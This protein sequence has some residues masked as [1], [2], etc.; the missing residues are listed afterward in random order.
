MRSTERL[1]GLLVLVGV[2]LPM[3]TATEPAPE[4]LE[5]NRRLLDIW[6]ADPDHFHRLQRDLA[7]FWELPAE[8]RERLR[9]LDR[10]LHDADSRTQKRLWGVLERYADWLERLPEADQQSIAT[11]ADKTERLQAIRD[12]RARQYFERLPAK[13]REELTRLSDKERKARLDQLKQEEQQLRRASVQYVQTRP[14]APARP[15]RPTRLDE[16]PPDVRQYVELSLWP[17]LSKEES[18]QVKKAEGAPWP[19]LARTLVELADKH[20]VLL[21]GPPTGPSHYRDLPDG[22]RTALPLKDVKGMA[23][24]RLRE[25]DGKWPEFAAEFTAIARQRDIKLPRQLGPSKPAE[26]AP[27]VAAFIERALTPKLTAKEK[28]DLKAAEGRWPDYPRLLLELARKHNLDVPLMRLP[29]PKALWDAARADLPDVPDRTLRE[30][31]LTELS[32]EE[33]TSLGLSDADPAG[34]ERLK[35]EFFKKNPRELQRLRKLDRQSMTGF[36]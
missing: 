2:G 13:T 11:A 8:R 19:L 24:K 21:P 25:L 36:K 16:F 10:D 18:D 5:R 3:L 28:D 17:Q 33:R 7:A 23:W 31:A 20:M 32:R 9:R 27:P 30:F 26:F 1:F 34:R 14:E 35:Q 22:V 4:D 12:I 29:G 15:G 6:R